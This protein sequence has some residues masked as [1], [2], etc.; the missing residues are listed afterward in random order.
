MAGNKDLHKFLIDKAWLLT[1]EWYESLDKSD[2]NG[3]YSSKYPEVIENIK[4]TKF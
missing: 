2:P 3:V 4:T 1:E